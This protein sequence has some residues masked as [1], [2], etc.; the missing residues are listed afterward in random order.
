MRF[1]LPL[2][3][4]LV[5]ILHAGTDE[6]PNRTEEA[7][8]ESAGVVALPVSNASLASDL[9]PLPALRLAVN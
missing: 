2:T 6:V 3:V 8:V 1:T 9:S 7:H 5:K 4:A